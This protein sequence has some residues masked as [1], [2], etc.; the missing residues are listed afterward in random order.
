MEDVLRGLPACGCPP[1]SYASLARDV[2]RLR[3]EARLLAEAA[4]KLGAGGLPPP[5]SVPWHE[6]YATIM[7]LSN[8]CRVCYESAM[9]SAALGVIAHVNEQDAGAAAA[10]AS[11]KSRGVRKRAAARRRHAYLIELCC[12]L[13][14]FWWSTGLRSGAG[15]G[16]TF[17]FASSRLSCCSPRPPHPACRCPAPTTPPPTIAGLKE[18]ADQR[19]CVAGRV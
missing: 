11:S 16:L 1:L 3:E 13:S 15:A 14:G 12:V 7:A 6:V 18:T 5:P 9:V 8:D 17:F 2:P 19:R 10:P 4:K